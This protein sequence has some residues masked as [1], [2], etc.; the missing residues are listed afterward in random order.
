VKVSQVST[1]CNLRA[2]FTW[3]VVLLMWRLAWPALVDLPL[4]IVIFDGWGRTPY[5]HSTQLVGNYINS[6][7]LGYH[8]KAPY[9]WWD[10]HSFISGFSHYWWAGHWKFHLLTPNPPPTPLVTNPPLNQPLPGLAHSSCDE[11]TCVLQLDRLHPV[12][13]AFSVIAS[14][15]WLSLN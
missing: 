15:C 11:A 12:A 8:G 1:F 6:G 4:G 5:L 2:N 14:R 9:F 7:W 3:T 10:F 13:R